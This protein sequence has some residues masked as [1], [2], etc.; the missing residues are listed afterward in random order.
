MLEGVEKAV[1]RHPLTTKPKPAY[2]LSHRTAHVLLRRMTSLEERASW[3][4][5]PA[6]VAAAMR[7]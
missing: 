3:T 7:G 6:V 1:A 5:V 4:K 2:H